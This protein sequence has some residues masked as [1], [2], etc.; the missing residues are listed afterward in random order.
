MTAQT[1]EAINYKLKSANLHVH[2]V[3]AW[4]VGRAIPNGD[5]LGVTGDVD[6]V[7]DRHRAHGGHHGIDGGGLVHQWGVVVLL[8]RLLHVELLVLDGRHRH[9]LGLR[10]HRG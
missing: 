3:R 6:H 5:R 9:V 8:H 10:G 2:V 4:A 1:R 7:H